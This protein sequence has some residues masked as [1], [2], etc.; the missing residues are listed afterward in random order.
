MFQI[1][2]QIRVVVGPHPN[3]V[4]PLQFLLKV[5]ISGPISACVEPNL[6]EKIGNYSITLATIHAVM[7]APTNV[8]NVHE[9]AHLC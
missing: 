9:Y 3:L 7:H 1:G 8:T 2:F 5:V 6:G 4:G